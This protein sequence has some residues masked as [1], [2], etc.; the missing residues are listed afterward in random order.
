MSMEV[1]SLLLFGPVSPRPSPAYLEQIRRSIKEKAGLKF[2]TG[3]V[4]ELPSLWSTIVQACPQLRS[5]SGAEQLDQLN[6]ILTSGTLPKADALSNLV[7]APLTVISQISEVLSQNLK[8]E[9]ATF[10]RSENVQGF[11]LGFL[12]AAAFT[13]SR[14]TTEFRQFASVAVRLAVCIRAVVDLDEASSEDR[15]SSIAIRWKIDSGKDS[16]RNILEDYPQ[17][18]G[19]CITDRSSI[20]VT[21]PSRGGTSFVLRLVEAGLSVQSIGLRGRYHHQDNFK[22]VQQMKEV[23]GSDRRLQLPTADRLVLPLRSNTDAGVIT[24]GALHE[25]ALNSILIEQSLWFQTVEATVAALGRK[26][27][28]V[29][30]TIG[31]YP[32]SMDGGGHPW[33]AA[34]STDGVADEGTLLHIIGGYPPSMDGGG[35]P[36]MV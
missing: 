17:A 21:I 26:N 22:A 15:S 31:G 20:T 7:A 11:C 12:T 18:Y 34:P 28:D 4:A 13:S 1:S 10:P 2:L 30:H 3:L 24:E 6:Q 32:P 29:L 25:I 33:T 9:D 35:Y 5:I 8:T 36:W 27:V 19:S 16:L 23:Y 14:D